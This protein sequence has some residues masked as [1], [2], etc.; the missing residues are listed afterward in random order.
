[1]LASASANR[2]RILEECAGITVEVS[3]SN[4]AEDL[5]KAGL[6]PAEYVIRTSEGKLKNKIAEIISRPEQ[7]LLICAD[8][9]VV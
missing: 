5:D 8:T 7:I 9:I 1:M 4:F 3:P 6:T 2:K